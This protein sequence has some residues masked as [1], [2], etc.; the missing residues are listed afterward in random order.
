[1]ISCFSSRI[2]TLLKY[3]CMPLYHNFSVRLYL[4]YL[5]RSV[6]PIKLQSPRMQLRTT[7][8]ESNTNLILTLLDD[9]A[10]I[11]QCVAFRI[12]HFTTYRYS[13]LT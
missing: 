4:F 10:S 12:L 2:F 13:A 1:M 8:A 6:A 7:A 9:C 11:Q 5:M 3:I